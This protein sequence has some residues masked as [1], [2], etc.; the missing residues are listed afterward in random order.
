MQNADFNKRCCADFYQEEVSRLL[1]GESMHPG[2]LEL[3][4]DLG[5]RLGLHKGSRVL[6]VACGIGTSAI[7]LAKEFGCHVTG[8]DLAD[9]NIDEAKNISSVSGVLELVDF[10]V[11]DAE[12]ID[13]KDQTFDC[14]VC[15]CSV[16][17]FPNKKKAAKEMYRVT[18]NGGRIGISDIVIRGSI[19]QSLRDSLYRFVCLLEAESEDTY[20]DLLQSAGYANTCIFDKKNAILQ[21]LDNINK[22]MFAVELLKGLRKIELK[23]DLERTK[24]AIREVKECVDS[25]I[26]SYVLITGEK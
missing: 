1:F 6:D 3:T 7:F 14:I 18:K 17:L 26:I 19:P 25:G 9:R 16:C 23:V 15:E 20:R 24:R 21:L 10:R 8:L 11:G 5:I 22:K 4:K 12:S 13:F 2:A